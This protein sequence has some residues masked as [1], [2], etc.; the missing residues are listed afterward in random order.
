MV[1]KTRS[2]SMT[3]LQRLDAEDKWV[4]VDDG[5]IIE[6]EHDDL[7][8]PT[9]WSN[10]NLKVVEFS[11]L[12]QRMGRDQAVRIMAA[13]QSILSNGGENVPVWRNGMPVLGTEVVR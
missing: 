3:D 12:Y 10:D 5:A 2:V 11:R 7:Y 8:D 13:C 9:C 4:E 1:D 6:G